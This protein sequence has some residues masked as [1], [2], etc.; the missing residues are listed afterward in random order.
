M[1]TGAHSKRL[2]VASHQNVNWFWAGRMS[3]GACTSVKMAGIRRDGSGSDC[4]RKAVRGAVTG[5]LAESIERKIHFLF[6]ITATKLRANPTER[7]A[8]IIRL[9][10]RF[11]KS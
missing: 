5:N 8:Y 3:P 11:S 1:P 6:F 7:M 9:R 10:S 2:E 4:G